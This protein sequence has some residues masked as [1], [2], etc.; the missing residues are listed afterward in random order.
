MVESCQEWICPCCQH[1]SPLTIKECPICLH[2]KK[3][4]NDDD[5]YCYCGNKIDIDNCVILITNGEPIYYC[6]GEC[7]R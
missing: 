1:Q 3:D 7:Y 5:K 2:R 6:C 4:N